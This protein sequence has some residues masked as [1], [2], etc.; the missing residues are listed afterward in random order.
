MAVDC[1]ANCR[2]Q[3]QQPSGRPESAYT[4]VAGGNG[5]ATF[6][7]DFQFN[8][9]QSAD[10]VSEPSAAVF[11]G[12]TH[13]A[14]AADSRHGATGG[15]RREQRCHLAATVHHRHVATATITAGNSYQLQVPHD[16]SAAFVGIC[17]RDGA[18]AAARCSPHS[19]QR[20]RRCSQKTETVLA[21]RQLSFLAIPNTSPNLSHPSLDEICRFSSHPIHVKVL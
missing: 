5:G 4:G 10:T 8:R 15:R 9:L 16:C 17:R 11:Y 1:L 18:N 6:A 20:C 19:S 2:G 7:V 21:H 12:D 3:R 14:A 13:H